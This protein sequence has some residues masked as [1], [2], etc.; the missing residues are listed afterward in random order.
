MLQA[1]ELDG[2]KI[3]HTTASSAVQLMDGNEITE[4]AVKDLVV[5]A[6]GGGMTIFLNHSYKVPEDVFGTSVDADLVMRPSQFGKLIADMDLD[7]AVDEANPRAVQTHASIMG[8]TK[9]GVS[10]GADIVDWEFIDEKA[11]FD[12]GVRFKKFLLRETSLVGLPR[13]PRGW[14]QSA[15]MALHSMSEP[16]D[17][18]D[19]LPEE[20]DIIQDSHPELPDSAFAA[21]DADGRHYPHHHEDGSIW[22]SLLRNALARVAD[23]GNSQAGK[24]HLLRHAK[25]Y[26]IGEHA[27]T[28]DLAATASNSCVT[29]GGTMDNPLNDCANSFHTDDDV[30]QSAEVPD[31]AIPSD[32][33]PAENVVVEEVPLASTSGDEPT[34]TN[35][36]TPDVTDGS[37]VPDVAQALVLSGADRIVVE[38]VLTTLEHTANE[39]RESRSR[40]AEL[41][42]S[43]LAITQ[44]RDAARL[45]LSEAGQIVETLARLPLGRKTAFVGPIKSFKERFSGVYDEAYLNL[46]DERLKED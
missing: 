40:V 24:G 7:V 37:V 27:D 22:M 28:P 12:G 41:E 23:P 34:V 20:P 39:L 2:R 25:E 1:A 36:A 15:V 45:D 32:A 35:D 4:D 46:I 38:M 9:I 42:A 31:L 3:I 17:F 11:R 33:A 10:I 8:G 6:K 13:N 30:A 21:V 16:D 44:E 43:N 26:N 14:V 19:E 18:I 29:C 5:Q